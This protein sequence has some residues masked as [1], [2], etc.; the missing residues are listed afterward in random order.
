MQTHHLE[1]LPTPSGEAATFHMAGVSCADQLVEL[2]DLPR[3][4]TT[5]HP[6]CNRT[7]FHTDRVVGEVCNEALST[8]HVYRCT[9]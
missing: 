1:T 8:R 6:T 5:G 9:H 2:Q 3:Q 7:L 4:E